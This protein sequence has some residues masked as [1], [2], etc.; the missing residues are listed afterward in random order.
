MRLKTSVSSSAK[1]DELLCPPSR[2]AMR[3]HEVNLKHRGL[4]A[5]RMVLPGQVA[6]VAT[7]GGHVHTGMPHSCPQERRNGVISVSSG[8]SHYFEYI[9]FVLNICLC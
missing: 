1:W 6:A 2:V 9:W 4:C 3:L 7:G 8:S 5:I